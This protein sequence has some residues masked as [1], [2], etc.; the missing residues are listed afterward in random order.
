MTETNLLTRCPH[1]QTRFKVSAEQL[2][3]AKGRV[4][5]GNCMNVFHA[6]E[7]KE[8]VAETPPPQDLGDGASPEKKELEAA[9]IED[10]VFQDNPEEDAA[11][12]KYIDAES[13][14]PDDELSDSFRGFDDQAADGFG[15]GDDKAPES[16]DESWAEDMLN[17]ERQQAGIPLS[18]APPQAA[19][20]EKTGPASSSAPG[21]G[22]TPERID[23]EAES[24]TQSQGQPGADVHDAWSIGEEADIPTEPKRRKSDYQDLGHEPIAIGGSRS[25]NGGRKT[26]WTLVVVALLGL[27]IAQVAYFQFDRLSSIPELRIFYE[28]A[29]ELAGCE[30][31]PLVAIDQIESRKLVVKTDPNDRQSLIVDAV[32]VNKADFEQPFPAIGLTFSNLN[33]DVVAQSLF[34]PEEY[35]SNKALELSAM[36]PE[37]PIQI[38]IRIRDPGRDAVNYNILFQPQG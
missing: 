32:I 16:A 22:E 17:E 24:D 28:K 14:F 23:L 25:G 20:P 9:S 3:I 36:P 33:G 11:E 7:N 35:L 19:A 34:T 12:G 38:R 26:L 2:G 8:S 29:C 30:L 4:R 31:E 10:F 18:D 37:T 1:C 5:C 15:V 6:V 13:S 21:P 27:L